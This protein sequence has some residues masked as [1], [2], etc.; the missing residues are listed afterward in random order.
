MA[1]AEPTFPN[2][3]RLLAPAT[4]LSWAVLTPSGQ[5]QGKHP[6]TSPYSR[7]PMHCV[8]APRQ[9]K[10]IGYTP[11][12][13]CCECRCGFILFPPSTSV[14]KWHYWHQPEYWLSSTITIAVQYILNGNSV[15]W[16]RSYTRGYQ[17]SFGC[18]YIASYKYFRI[19]RM[20]L[21]PFQGFGFLCT[22]KALCRLRFKDVILDQVTSI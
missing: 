18:K 1:T 5:E 11:L 7:Q 3:P 16:V 19:R 8:P 20:V 17:V 10:G 13:L 12:T 6:V 9:G 2:H 22:M 15:E 21:M 4:A 14:Q